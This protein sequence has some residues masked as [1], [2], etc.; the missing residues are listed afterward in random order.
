[1]PR[2]QS[3]HGRHSRGRP[4]AR[5][6]RGAREPIARGAAG[7]MAAWPRSLARRP[8]TQGGWAASSGARLAA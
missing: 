6:G 8:Q 2:G 5:S 7:A 3:R 4:Q 1:V